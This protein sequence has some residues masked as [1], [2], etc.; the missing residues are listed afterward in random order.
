MEANKKSARYQRLLTQITGLLEKSPD[1]TARMSTI[2][3]VLS[4]KMEYFFWCGFYRV[5]G[6]RLIVGPYQGPVACQVLEG[7]GVCLKAV[8]QRKTILVDDVHAFPGHIACDSRSLS[9]IVV[10]VYN[11]QGEIIA[12][13][14]VDSSQKSSFDD[15]DALYLE[16]IVSLLKD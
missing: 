5:D 7:R 2:C 11:K 14:D 16:Q 9:E 3:A 13:L 10:P 8:E 15:V 1:Q 4:H 12:V 6:N